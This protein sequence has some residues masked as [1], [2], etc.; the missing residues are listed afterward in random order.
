MVAELATFAVV[1]LAVAA[2]QLHARRCRR[3]AVLAFGPGRKPAPWARLAPLL[4]VGALAGLCW[5][6]TTLLLLP[7]KAHKTGV[8]PEHEYRH[9]LLVLDV[10]PSMRLQDAGP[11]GKQS[12]AQRAAD[13]LKSFFERTP[14]DRYR[15]SVVAVHTGAKP[16][17]INTTDLDV[18]RNILTDLPLHFAFKAGPTNL[19]AGL[20]EAARIAHPWRPKST[21]LVVL[22]DGDTVPATGMPKMPASVAHVLIVGVGDPHAG[23]F[24]DGHHSRQDTSTLR[25]LAVRLGGTYHNG[26]EKHLSTD[27][28]KQ[29]TAVEGQGTFEKLTRREYALLACG[30]G[31]FV[32]ALLPLALHLFGT[33]W[34]PGV[35]P[36]TPRPGGTILPIQKNQKRRLTEAAHIVE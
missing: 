11:T 18:I 19:F 16:V 21:T 9:L 28:L 29:I 2:E 36:G 23:R 35:Q 4:R 26:N 10:S 20:E 24:I 31:A 30:V 8:I 13:I 27:L 14:I 7:P 12:R 1:V 22:S 5:G 17:A 3:V 33:R 32:L 6:L 34:K 15:I 25:Q